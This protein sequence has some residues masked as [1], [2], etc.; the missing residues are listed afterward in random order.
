MEPINQEKKQ[1]LEKMVGHEICP[2]IATTQINMYCIG[3]IERYVCSVD[4]GNAR[5]GEGGAAS[6][7]NNA[8]TPCSAEYAKTCPLFRL[9]A[10]KADIEKK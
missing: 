9:H 8:E 1:E 10:A 4:G 6:Y 5:G 2:L 7:R 3:K